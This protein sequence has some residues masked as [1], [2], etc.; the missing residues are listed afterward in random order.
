M[1][2]VVDDDKRMI[3]AVTLVLEHEGHSVNTAANGVEAYGLLKSQTCDLI[4]LDINMPGL[5]GPELLNLMKAEGI[6][7]PTIV[8]TGSEEFDFDSL[9]A[10][11]FVVGLER[12]PFDISDLAVKIH[13]FTGRKV[14]VSAISDTNRIDGDL[15]LPA[16]IDL[17]VFLAQ[18]GAFIVLD[19]ASV[20]TT[21]GTPVLESPSL[22]L[23][24]ASLVCLSA[25]SE[26]IL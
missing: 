22:T 2:L 16:T 25:D 24:V 6:W 10:F 19:N 5:S 14:R 3:E 21:S 7:I 15:A 9:A 11:P 8:M 12:K 17:P 20:M 23:R 13:G 1:I 18:A 26:A 4:L